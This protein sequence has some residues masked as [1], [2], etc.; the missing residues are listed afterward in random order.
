MTR[1]RKT[2]RDEQPQHSAEAR[3]AAPT[4][5]ALP[6]ASLLGLPAASGIL[7]YLSFPPADLWPLAYV[8]L[9]PLMVALRLARTWKSAGLCGLVAG[10]LAYLPGLVWLSSVTVAGWIGLSAYVAAY[11]AAFALVVQR[12]RRRFPRAW[13]LLVAAVWVGLEFIRSWLGTGFPWLLVGHTQYRF[14]SL[15]QVASLTGVY[16]VT[17]LLVLVNASI[18][19]SVNVL[20]EPPDPSRHR[21]RLAPLYPVAAVALV[22]LCAVGGKA[23]ASRVSVRKGPVVGVVQ[24]NVPRLVSEIIPP[25][26]VIEARAELERLFLDVGEE[27]FELTRSSLPA[28]HTWA[29]YEDEVYRRM[30]AEIEKAAALSESL[31]G[32]GARLIAWPETTV[33]VPL[34]IAPDLNPDPRSRE[35]QQSVLETLRRLGQMMDCYMLVGAPSWFRMSEGYVAQV[36]YDTTVKNFGNSA[37]LFTP[38]GE[39]AGRY[40]KM[41]LVPFGEYVP[42][43]DVLP[44]LQYFTPMTRDITPGDEEVVFELPLRDGKTARF[45]ALVCYEGVIAP[46]VREFRRKG[47][48]FFVN[49]TDEGWYRP[50]GEL[51]QHVAMDVFRAVE[52][53]TTFVRAA[54]TGVSCFIN[55][56]GEIYAVVKENV[57]G[58]TRVTDVQGAIS[59]PV[60]ISDHVPPYVHVGDA[61]AWACLLAAVAVP[62]GAYVRG[63]RG[64]R[65]ALNERDGA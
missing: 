9:V 8:A 20:L 54:N 27:K 28:Y 59:A 48:E 11:M 31:A 62:L 7:L 5:R 49:V 15:I 46:L 42:L 26:D 43:R 14:I 47:A 1:K 16:G 13:P 63:R 65:P 33:Q 12:A 44:F 25:A 22:V 4:R 39:F 2:R 41:H 19:E 56:R 32:Q 35:A 18:A 50:P 24:Q 53:R 30:G 38:K 29:A 58:R 3:S 64:S 52:T 37:V 45:G 17:F 60:Y 57:G 36:R 51:N 6:W 61:F 34:N 10:L 55:P 23:A 21:M 40:D